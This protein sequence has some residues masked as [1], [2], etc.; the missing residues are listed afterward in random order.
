MIAWLQVDRKGKGIENL[1][2]V[3]I[4]G[5]K[6]PSAKIRLAKPN[7]YEPMRSKTSCL[8]F[9]ASPYIEELAG[10]QW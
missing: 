9:Q 6:R 3:R 4:V 5:K 1:S 2:S 10:T 8:S 7:K